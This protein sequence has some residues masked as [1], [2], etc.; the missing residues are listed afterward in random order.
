MEQDT[1]IALADKVRQG[2]ATKEEA[3]LVMEHL[4]QSL[5]LFEQ[6]INSTSR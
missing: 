3:R 4:K 5:S 2:I 1:V 6:L